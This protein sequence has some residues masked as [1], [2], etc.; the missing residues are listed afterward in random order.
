MVAS[1]LQGSARGETAI[2]QWAG[3]KNVH[4]KRSC[5]HHTNFLLPLQIPVRRIAW[6]SAGSHDGSPPKHPWRWRW[7]SRSLSLSLSLSPSLS[8]SL[9]FFYLS[10]SLSISLSISLYIYIYIYVYIYTIHASSLETRISTS[11]NVLAT[12]LR[13]SICFNEAVLH[14]LESKHMFQ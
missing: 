13:A 11:R 2:V 14:R 10:L 5:I 4:I 12:G 9:S 8:F 7:I 1:L 6:T 3:R